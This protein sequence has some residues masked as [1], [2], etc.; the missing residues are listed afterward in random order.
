MN[1]TAIVLNTN[2]KSFSLVYFIEQI[3]ARQSPD[4]LK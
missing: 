4:N 3:T 2:W 1:Y